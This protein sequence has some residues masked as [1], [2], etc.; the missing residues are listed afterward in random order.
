VSVTDT[1]GVDEVVDRLDRD[2]Y[3]IVE[4]LFDAEETSAIKT[5]LTRILESVPTGR[6]DFEGWH[7]RRIYSVFAKT[8]MLDGA[9]THP[10]VLGALDRFLGEHYQLSAPTGIEIGPGEVAQVL[11]H[12]DGIYPVPQPHAELV[13]NVMWAFDDFT[14]K[15]GAT[16]IVPGS[17]RGALDQAGSD[18][19]TV[20]AEMPAG[21]AMIYLGSVW[22]GGGAN[23]TESA[24]L[25]VAIEYVA[26]WLRPQ[27]TQLL[28]VPRETARTLSPRLQELLGYDVYPPFVGYV[29]GRHPRRVLER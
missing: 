29:D 13:T 8:R 1:A 19:P 18:T 3:A 6:N 4:R 17:H 26:G 14:E 2:G 20:A 23:R 24:R 28:A 22:H 7:T 11:H 9:A 12:D 21:S 5:E 15:N 16:R 27:E 10:L 25:G